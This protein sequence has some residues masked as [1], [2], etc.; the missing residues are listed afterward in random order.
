MFLK[1]VSNKGRW[2]YLDNSQI[3]RNVVYLLKE[4][5]VS[6]YHLIDE[7]GNEIYRPSENDIIREDF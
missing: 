6:K 2:A 3:Y 5:D 1:L 4:N 7:N